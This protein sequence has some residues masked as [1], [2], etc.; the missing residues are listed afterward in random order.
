MQHTT[1][2][3]AAPPLPLWFWLGALVFVTLVGLAAAHHDSLKHLFDG[4]PPALQWLRF[5]VVRPFHS[6][7]TANFLHPLFFVAF[8]AILL[9]EWWMPARPEQRIFSRALA[10][11]ALYVPFSAILRAV[12]LTGL[13]EQLD[14][15]Y[16]QRLAFLISESVRTLPTCVR[17]GLGFLLLDLSSWLFHRLHH[18]V[19]WLWQIH[20]VHHSQEDL[21]LFTNG[22]GHILETATFFAA[23]SLPMYILRMDASEYS[24]LM[25]FRMWHDRFNHSNV[26][27][28]LGMLRHVLVTPQSHRIHH[29]IDPRHQDRNF[30]AVLSVWDRAFGTLYRGWDEYPATGIS[31]PGFPRE[32]EAR[33]LRF[34]LTPLSQLVYPVRRIAGSLAPARGVTSGAGTA[35]HGS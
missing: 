26:R 5:K 11:D 6:S 34:L 32:Q 27:T 31:D 18:A 24:L 16:S 17:V 10:H 28:N 23:V 7:I 22:R 3:D 33:G 8:P 15:L 4:A 20:A 12:L 30:G 14:A 2:R 9:L 25:L 1:A 29:S 13:F 21:N 19:P 35:T